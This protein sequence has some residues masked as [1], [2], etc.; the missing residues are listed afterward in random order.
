MFFEEIIKFYEVDLPM[1]MDCVAIKTDFLTY[2]EDLHFEITE[3][4]LF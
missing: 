2:F 1:T 3:R 4:I